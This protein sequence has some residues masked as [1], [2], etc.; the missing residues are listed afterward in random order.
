MQVVAHNMLAQFTSRQLNITSKDKEKKSEKLSSG[1]RIN[2]SADDAAGLSISE[3]M[4]WQIRGLG[5]AS[6]NI[7]DGISLLQVADGALNE[8]HGILQRTRELS[9]QAANDTN[10][11]Q[12]REAIQKEVDKLLLEIDRIGNDTE[13]NTRKI[14]KGGYTQFVDENGKPIAISKVPVADLNL[15][16]PNLMNYPFTENSS[17]QR[18]NL[19]VSTN[20]KYS[21]QAEWGLVYSQGGTSHSNVRLT[22]ED[23]SGNDVSR[24][25]RL[26]NMS[27]SDVSISSDGKTCERTFN[28]RLSDEVSIQIKQ[29]I[30]VGTNDGSKQY[31]DI[32]HTI[33]NNGTKDLKSAELLFNVDTAYNDN[34]MCEEYFIDGS[35]VDK[36]CMYSDNQDYK[37]Q[38]AD[39]KGM[40]Q[41]TGNGFSIIDS[42]DALSFSEKIYWETSNGPETVLIGSWPENTGS[43]GYYDHLAQHLGGTT[44]DKDLAFSIIWNSKTLSANSSYTAGALHYGIHSAKDDTNLKGVNIKYSQNDKIHVDQLDLW[45]Q[46]SAL[47]GAGQ[48]ITIGEMNSSVLGMKGIDVSSYESASDSITTVDKAIGIISKQRTDIGAQTNRLEHSKLIDDNTRENTQAAESRLR[49][50][51]LADEMVEYSKNSILEQAAQ[52]MLAQANQSSQSVLSLFS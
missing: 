22:Y 41:F 1:Y 13:F 24:S 18:L 29:K 15:G 6:N 36:F 33:I 42:E 38:S 48:F 25:C 50:S 17:G 8:V 4:R 30:T 23:D 46:S 11:A 27:I 35:K 2:R 45:I 39:I 16:G 52:S 44:E 31:Y 40:N 47:E 9:V 5:K 10:T 34:D 43:W 7:E 20:D 51:D 19:S 26:E 12:D 3:K 21:I 14:F 37:T 28:Y 32:Q 49:D